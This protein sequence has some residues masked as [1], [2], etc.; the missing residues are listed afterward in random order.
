M[1]PSHHTRFAFILLAAAGC[2]PDDSGANGDSGGTGNPGEDSAE[3][4]KEFVLPELGACE[5]ASF[6]HD[7][8]PVQMGN[9]WWYVHV[10][11]SEFFETFVRLLD[12]A[13]ATGC[14]RLTTT[15]AGVILSGDCEAEGV[16]FVGTWTH[17]G[18]LDRFE[19]VEASVWYDGEELVVQ[20]EGEVV[21]S[22][23]TRDGK[24]VGVTI[25]ANLAYSRSGGMVTDSAA[26]ATGVHLQI[27]EQVYIAEGRIAHDWIGGEGT[28][29]PVVDIVAAPAC[30]EEADGYYALQGEDTWLMLTNGSDS[31]DACVDIFLNGEWDSED[32]DFEPMLFGG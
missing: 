1:T 4:A 30:P 32:C 15:E 29:C 2:V 7:N 5:G 11:G 18:D 10:S 17:E 20:A 14:P 31:C 28:I 27:N 21:E 12:S 23:D 19:G 13:E 8:G 26:V 24:H 16:S 22:Y 6:V 3:P 9:P 25:D